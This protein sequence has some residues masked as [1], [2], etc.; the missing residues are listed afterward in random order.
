MLNSKPQPSGEPAIWGGI[1]RN[2]VLKHRNYSQTDRAWSLPLSFSK[3]NITQFSNDGFLVHQ[4][5]RGPGSSKPNFWRAIKSYPKCDGLALELFNQSLNVLVRKRLKRIFP[6]KLI[7]GEIKGMPSV[8]RGTI[9]CPGSYQVQ[10]FWAVGIKLHTGDCQRST[11]SGQWAVPGLHC[12]PGKQE[13]A[14]DVWRS[15]SAGSSEWTWLLV[16]GL[17]QLRDRQ[18]HRLHREDYYGTKIQ[19][20]SRDKAINI[21][22][23]LVY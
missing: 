9:W 14:E 3:W 17:I 2:G 13:Q 21:A 20:G 11:L 23:G 15:Q 5:S 1:L 19:M 6:Q 8:A 16:T 22:T 18:Y 10:I 7:F 12:H 4:H